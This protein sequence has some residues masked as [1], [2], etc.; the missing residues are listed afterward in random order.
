MENCRTV[1]EFCIYYYYCR[2]IFDWSIIKSRLKRL[3]Y[4]GF[5]ISLNKDGRIAYFTT[6]KRIE[7]ESMDY[8]TFSS[9]NR[10][11]VILEKEVIKV[12]EKLESYSK[13]INLA[14]SEYGD[15]GLQYKRIY[16]GFITDTFKEILS[17]P[18]NC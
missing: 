4:S 12:P 13:S 16:G 8:L 18:K 1:K 17:I 14:F 7:K 11:F 15:Y 2:K 3:N 5:R 9:D 6:D 10:P